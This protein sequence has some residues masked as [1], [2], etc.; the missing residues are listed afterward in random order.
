MSHK[1]SEV[2]ITRTIISAL[3]DIHL[4]TNH[5]KTIWKLKNTFVSR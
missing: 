3:R 4:E 2:R 5:E 1:T